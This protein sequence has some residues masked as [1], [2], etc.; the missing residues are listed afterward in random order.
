MVWKDNGELPT[1]IAEMD[2][3]IKHAWRTV[4][5]RNGSKQPPSVEA[6]IQLYGKHLRSPPVKVQHISGQKLHDRAKEMGETTANI[7]G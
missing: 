2:A 7:G 4:N 1:N 3:S 6:F 5:L